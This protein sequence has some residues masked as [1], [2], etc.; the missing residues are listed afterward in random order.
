VGVFPNSLNTEIVRVTSVNTGTDTLTI[1]RGQEGSTAITI[2]SGNVVAITVTAKSLTDIEGAVNTVGNGLPA[3]VNN[4]NPTQVGISNSA[5]ASEPAAA[6]G[7]GN[8]ASGNSCTAVGVESES[9]GDYSLTVGFENEATLAFGMA[10]GNNNSATGLN[11]MAVGSNNYPSASHAVSIGANLLTTT[12][13]TVEIGVSNTN[14]LQVSAAGVNFVTSGSGAF[15]VNGS[16]ISGVQLASTTSPTPP[17]NPT[18]TSAPAIF[19]QDSATPT[20]YMWSI[21]GQQWVG[22]ITA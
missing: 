7:C 6:L 21:T 18:N 5:N 20:L 13:S 4:L 8:T 16:P 19:Y 14:K 9:I 11:A 12:A 3:N 2:V 1:A 15:T 17:A 22:I 10:V